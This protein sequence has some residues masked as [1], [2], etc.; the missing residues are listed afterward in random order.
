MAIKE[1]EKDILTKIS[2]MIETGKKGWTTKELEAL[3]AL[4]QGD[5]AKL[6]PTREIQPSRGAVQK[7]ME[8]TACLDAACKGNLL[9][10]NK[11]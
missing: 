5:R 1:K 9:P 2:D 4:A 8:L 11:W 6:I 3:A 10:L 7:T